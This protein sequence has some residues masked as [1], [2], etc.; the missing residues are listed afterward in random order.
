MELRPE[1][2]V[3]LW[4]EPPDARARLGGARWSPTCSHVICWEC[5]THVFSSPDAICPVCRTGDVARL[6]LDYRAAT[7]YARR[8]VSVADLLRDR[9]ERHRAAEQA[10]RR[11]GE[12]GGAS[13]ASGADDAG[14]ASAGAGHPELLS[15]EKAL[16]LKAKLER[17]DGARRRA[18]DDSSVSYSRCTSAGRRTDL[19]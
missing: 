9:L 19:S 7:K 4:P 5:A 13:G 1:T 10:G 8:T 2:S 17:L 15:P 11:L 16:L 14:E 18:E 6:K 3:S 12:R